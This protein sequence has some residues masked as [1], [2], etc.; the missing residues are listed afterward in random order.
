MEFDDTDA[1]TEDIINGLHNTDTN[2]V[3]DDFKDDDDYKV[4]NLIYAINKLL[5][6]FS[7]CI[8]FKML[9]ISEVLL[10]GITFCNFI[11]R[12]HMQECSQNYF[13]KINED[14]NVKQINEDYNN[15]VNNMNEK[16]KNI[17]NFL[18][19]SINYEKWNIENIRTWKWNKYNEYWAG[20][21]GKKGLET[22]EEKID[23]ETDSNDEEA[24]EAQEVNINDTND[25]EEAEET[26][27]NDEE[28][29]EEMDSNDEEEAEEVN[30]NDTNDTN[31]E[32]EAE[33][34]DSND[35][36][37]AEEMDSNDEEESEET[38]SNDEEIRNVEEVILQ[39][40][41]IHETQIKQKLTIELPDESVF[42][43]PKNYDVPTI[44]KAFE[45][46]EID[47][48]SDSSSPDCKENNIS[49]VIN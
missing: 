45:Y 24:E 11:L 48:F 19:S 23:E 27:S 32:E 33:E 1:N 42:E 35:E 3:L 4:I 46:D 25:E 20:E 41:D 39:N 16:M 22:I 44:K 6:Y 28:E 36:E 31:D 37:E 12:I 14:N 8:C 38:D 34:M 15:F 13:Q 5:F 18:S 21:K 10:V 9:H 40:I 2:E 49:Q 7:Q 17:S 26:D 43:M 47:K 29:A 30:I